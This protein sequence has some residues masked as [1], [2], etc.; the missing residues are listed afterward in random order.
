MDGYVN[1]LD[2]TDEEK[3]ME[4][5]KNIIK[6][7]EMTHEVVTKSKLRSKQANDAIA[8]GDKIIMWNVLQEYLHNYH[9]LLAVSY[10][11]CICQVDADFYNQVTED[12]L[13]KQLKIVIG[14]IYAYEATHCVAKEKIK[15][16][17]KKLLKK[18][19]VFSDKEIERLVL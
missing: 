16:C 4:Y 1:K 6:A 19:G 8:T 15:A 17:F 12:D 5:C 14:L 13:E 2:Y 9:K 7:V 18:S 10:G 3:V 11:V